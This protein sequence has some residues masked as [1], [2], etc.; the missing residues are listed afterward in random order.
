M[1]EKTAKQKKVEKRSKAWTTR[2]GQK[3]LAYVQ[4]QIVYSAM[5]VCEWMG[6]SAFFKGFD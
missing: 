1:G 5:S 6:T 3:R 4:E 2:W